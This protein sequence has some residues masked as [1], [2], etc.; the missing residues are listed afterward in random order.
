MKKVWLALLLGSILVLAACGGGEEANNDNTDTVVNNNQGAT[1]NT[2]D[3]DGATENNGDT[4]GDDPGATTTD[5]KT[6]DEGAVAEG[7]AV[8]QQACIACHGQNLEGQGNFPA[9]NNVGSRLSQEEI[10]NV[11]KNGKGMMSANIVKGEDAEAAA[12]YLATLK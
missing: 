3:N 8:V 12:A 1:D 7:K 4:T 5:T 9:L 11:I 2:E 10:L 6:P